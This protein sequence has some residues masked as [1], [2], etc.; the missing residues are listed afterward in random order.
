M[1]TETK[2]PGFTRHE[3]SQYLWDDGAV[4]CDQSKRV[5]DLEDATTALYEALHK[6]L[7]LDP[8]DL[9]DRRPCATCDQAR[10]ALAKAEAL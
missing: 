3:L 10:A 4:T 8:H 2:A 7:M 1:T 9:N 5:R 6:L